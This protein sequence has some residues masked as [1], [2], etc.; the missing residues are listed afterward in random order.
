MNLV[1]S[2]RAERN[3]LA[4]SQ[5]SDF[6]CSRARATKLGQDPNVRRHVRTDSPLVP[7]LPKAQ[8]KKVGRRITAC[9]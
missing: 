4:K 8:E 7:P 1:G 6:E 2:D 9:G 3:P 5:L